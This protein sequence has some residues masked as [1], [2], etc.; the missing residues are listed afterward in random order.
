MAGSTLTK[1]VPQR[2]V[3]TRAP[4]RIMVREVAPPPAT[5]RRRR[6]S[7]GMVGGSSGIMGTPM[8][9]QR[10]IIGYALG[11]LQREGTLSRLPTIAQLGAEGTIALAAGFFGRGNA[12]M[13]DLSLCA[14]I[15]AVNQLGR[16]GLTGTPRAPATSGVGA[17]VQKDPYEVQGDDGDNDD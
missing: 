1:S 2:Q 8:T 7:S 10:L 15:V 14:G 9:G 16:E 17:R 4:T 5:T 12:M 6:R 3:P 13:Q 11:A